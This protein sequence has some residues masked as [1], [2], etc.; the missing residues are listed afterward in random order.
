MTVLSLPFLEHPRPYGPYL[1][2]KGARGSQGWRNLAS[3][4]GCGT[5]S[6]AQPLCPGVKLL[7]AVEPEVWLAGLPG[8]WSPLPVAG[9]L[10][11]ELRVR[12]GGGCNCLPIRGPGW[13]EMLQVQ[14]PS[15]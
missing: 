8:V 10:S 9:V 15:A 5:S 3:L 4:R 12:G 1:D 6:L 13:Q 14:S 7:S 2:L 11:S